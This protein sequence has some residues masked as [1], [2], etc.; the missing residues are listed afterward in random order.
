M[1]VSYNDGTEGPLSKSCTLDLYNDT[2][3]FEIKNYM[4]N[5]IKDSIIPLQ[6]SKL[7]GTG[8]FNPLYLKNG[9]LY[10]LELNYIDPDTG[11]RVSKFILPENPDGRTLVIVVRL[12]EGLYQYKPMMDND[13]VELEPLVRKV[14][15]KGKEK[16]VPVLT[17][18]N[19]Q[20]YVFKSTTLQ[21]CKDYNQK[22]GSYNIKPY[23]KP[24]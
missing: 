14:K 20:L 8:Y 15:V 21:P 3:V 6:G 13:H 11:E 17:P 7:E 10:N 18:E 12:K 19:K 22:D 2:Y 23:L 4:K 24:I 1:I 16:N 9:E 5:S